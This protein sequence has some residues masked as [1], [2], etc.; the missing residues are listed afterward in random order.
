MNFTAAAIFAGICAGLVVV[1]GVAGFLAELF[2]EPNWDC[3]L[4]DQEN[5]L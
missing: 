4:T 5:D 3:S 1:A 2:R